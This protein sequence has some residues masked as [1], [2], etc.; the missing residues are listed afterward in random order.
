M[1]Q[2][3]IINEKYLDKIIS[4]AYGDAG[5]VDKLSIYRDARKYPEVKKI[6]DEYR[7]TAEEVKSFAGEK[8]PDDLVRKIEK[9]IPGVKQNKSGKYL[10][11]FRKPVFSSVALVMVIAIAAFLIFRQPNREPKYSKAE[12]L[13]AEIQIKQSLGLV[14]KIFRQT[15]NTISQDVLDKQVVPPIKRGMNVVNNLLNGG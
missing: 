4:V 14:G 9:V 7:T 8:C 6:L 11:A 3:K 15:Q 10:I 5:I 13:T 12:V 1:K 2:Q